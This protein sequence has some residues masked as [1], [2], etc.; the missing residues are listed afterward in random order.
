[1]AGAAQSASPGTAPGI[2]TFNR[3]KDALID[4]MRGIEVI[5]CHEHLQAETTRVSNPVDI[6]TLFN[7]YCVHDIYSSRPPEKVGINELRTSASYLKDFQPGS[8][9]LEER[10]N[11]VSPALRDIQNGS[12]FRAPKITL[13]D[14]YGVDQLND[15]NYMEVTEK[16]R[17]ANKPGLYHEILR[18]RG[19]IKTCLVQFPWGPFIRKRSRTR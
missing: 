8:A 15:H 9:P 4:F 7:L 13:R 19:N 11:R 17:A 12:Y 5:D 6:L 10:W 18:E 1:M 14:I 16:M 2:L 3:T